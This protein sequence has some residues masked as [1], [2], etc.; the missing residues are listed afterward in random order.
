M[1]NGLYNALNS[2]ANTPHRGSVRATNNQVHDHALGY[3]AYR[4]I[5]QSV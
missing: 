1:Q 4:V 2:K 3:H 5:P